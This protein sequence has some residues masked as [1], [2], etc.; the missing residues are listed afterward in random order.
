MI[1]NN[2]TPLAFR[3]L[4]KE[5]IYA[6]S[7]FY[8][9]DY[10]SNLFKSYK[11]NE[12]S[13]YISF[14]LIYYIIDNKKNNMD[15]IYFYNQKFI[16]F[17]NRELAI[18][19]LYNVMMYCDYLRLNDCKSIIYLNRDKII[20]LIMDYVNRIS[21]VNYTNYIY[22]CVGIIN[23]AANINIITINFILYIE[24]NDSK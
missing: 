23:N 14:H 9:S 8:S 19:L 24:R 3:F 6:N 7:I 18:K 16:K 2:L 22:H 4:K 1:N 10:I 5:R 12:D 20:S 15:I 11:I 21:Y 17:I 13:F